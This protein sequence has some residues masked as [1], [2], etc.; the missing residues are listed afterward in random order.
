[1]PF[2]AYQDDDRVDALTLDPQEWED[3]RASDAYPTL[4]L[5]CGIRAIAKVSNLGTQFFAHHRT[6]GCELEHLG[7]TK[8]HLAM[9]QAVVEHINTLPGWS[10]VV[11]YA[12]QDRTWIADVMAIHENGRRAAFEVQLSHQAQEEW[13]SRTQRYF[14]AGVLPI[15][16]TPLRTWT[17]GGIDLPLLEVPFR[18]STPL[19]E[20]PADLLS[21]E[22]PM[23]NWEN[24]LLRAALTRILN[25]T[26]RWEDGTPRTQ[27]AAK[28]KERLQWEAEDRRR[29]IAR[30][31]M[32]AAVEK[33]NE[34]ARAPFDLY[35]FGAVPSVGMPLYIWASV[36]KCWKCRQ[37]ML[38]WSAQDRNQLEVRVQVG[39]KRF[40]NHPAV[41][42]SVDAWRESA[43]YPMP[44]AVIELRSYG[45]GETQSSFTCPR[46]KALIGQGFVANLWREKW[47]R[48]VVPPGFDSDWK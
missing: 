45:T 43:G 18:K 19:P 41:H 39:L 20:T 8:Q 32:E 21:L 12:N 42:R 14:D 31:K 38:L 3:L 24:F 22:T 33:N 2:V 27:H 13:E 17:Q 16:I 4:E 48:I 26:T 36:S 6:A 28:E 9:K 30:A 23:W 35:P 7:E 11:E 1:M 34:N 15:W 47:S 29:E 25:G 44:K 37:H 40:E 10:A 5:A 46:C